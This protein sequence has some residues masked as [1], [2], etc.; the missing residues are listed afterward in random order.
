MDGRKGNSMTEAEIAQAMID[1]IAHCKAQWYPEFDVMQYCI[2]KNSEG[3][4]FVV[5]VTNSV[6]EL[7]Q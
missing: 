4:Q 1:I 6:K 2:E 5:D 3:L 7:I